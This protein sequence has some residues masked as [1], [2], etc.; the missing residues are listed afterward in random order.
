M[1]SGRHRRPSGWKKRP[2]SWHRRPS[3]WRTGGHLARRSFGR[4][5]RP[6]GRHRRPTDRHRTRSPSDRHRPFAR[7]RRPSGRYRVTRISFIFRDYNFDSL[8]S[9]IMFPSCD[10]TAKTHQKRRIFKSSGRLVGG[11]AGVVRHDSKEEVL[12]CNENLVHFPRL[13]LQFP[14]FKTMFPSCNLTAKTH[15]KRRAF[16]TAAEDL[17]GVLFP[18]GA[19][20][21]PRWN[22]RTDAGPLAGRSDAQVGGRPDLARFDNN[23]VQARSP[24]PEPTPIDSSNYGHEI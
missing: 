7:H 19:A 22:V 12:K 11:F 6:S 2:S 5:R 10:L 8:A 14:G 15:H 23:S 4:H 3:G 16:R 17:P 9:K 18:T 24:R 21:G 13:Q 20:V 1:P